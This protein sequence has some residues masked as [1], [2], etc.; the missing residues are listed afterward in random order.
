VVPGRSPKKGCGSRER[1]QRQLRLS[2]DPE[3]RRRD[4][5]ERKLVRRFAEHLE[6]LNPEQSKAMRIVLES[7][8]PMSRAEKEAFRFFE[9][10]VRPD[11]DGEAL[12]KPNEVTGEEKRALEA[13]RVWSQSWQQRHLAEMYRRFPNSPSL[14]RSIR[15][16][17][18]GSLLNELDLGFLEQ[19]IEGDRTVTDR[20]A[21]DLKTYLAWRSEQVEKRVAQKDLLGRLRSSRDQETRA[22]DL[23]QLRYCR[24]CEQIAVSSTQ[25]ELRSFEQCPFCYGGLIN[26]GQAVSEGLAV[27]DER[28]FWTVRH[29]PMP[30]WVGQSGL[31]SRG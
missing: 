9:H 19:R 16:L 18:R 5:Q 4:I 20:Q 15:K 1:H 14:L 8:A 6:N 31:R 22:I 26:L 25:G 10:R 13:L 12:S 27:P 11:S 3:A 21:Q 23:E 17:Q 7:E 2:S 28:G 29:P 30:D 24:G